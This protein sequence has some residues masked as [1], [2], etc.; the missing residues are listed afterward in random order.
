[1]NGAHIGHL[2]WAPRLA[3]VW[4][5]LGCTTEQSNPSPPAPSKRSA[6]VE[7]SKSAGQSDT[8][9]VTEKSRVEGR[10]KF[11]RRAVVPV[12]ALPK[13]WQRFAKSVSAKVLEARHE[14]WSFHQYWRGGQKIKLVARIFGMDAEVDERILK[15]LKTMGWPGLKQPLSDQKSEK[16]LGRWSITVDRVVAAKGVPRETQ[17]ILEATRPPKPFPMKNVPCGRFNAVTGWRHLPPWMYRCLTKNTTRR[18]VVWEH[19]E[20]PKKMVD[21]QVML[22]HNGFAHDENIG[23]LTQG[24]GAAGYALKA[25]AGPR[26][27]W[28]HPDGSTVRFTP[29]PQDFDFG[30]A[31]D[32][33]ILSIEWV[34]PR[35]P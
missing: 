12:D 20:T 28:T 4:A 15:A 24:L 1:M 22:Y 32:G 25:G 10:A 17:L 11:N 8:V 23:I 34:R 7:A 5:C 26:Q 30:C 13:H 2:R 6:V 35:T 9:A 14:R 18:R 33:P 29:G 19:V 21:Y 16:G 27:L 3:L 31:L